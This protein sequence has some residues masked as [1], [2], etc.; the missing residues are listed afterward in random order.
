MTFQEVIKKVGTLREPGES[1][2]ESGNKTLRGNHGENG[3]SCYEYWIEIENEPN[4]SIEFHYT[5]CV[6]C[7]CVRRKW[8]V[9]F[10]KRSSSCF[11]RETYWI[12]NTKSAGGSK[13]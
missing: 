11:V 8:F 5:H 6:E 2:I 10:D 3:H 4:H 12:K 1:A 13:V 7:G 9:A